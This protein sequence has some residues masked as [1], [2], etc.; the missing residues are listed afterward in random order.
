[1]NRNDRHNMRS[2]IEYR[3]VGVWERKLETET[4]NG[5]ALIALERGRR[6]ITWRVTS[7]SGMDSKIHA[8]IAWMKE[9]AFLERRLV[10]RNYN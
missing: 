10:T 9:R 7:A 1:M 3:L 4:G 2:T 6:G 5:N 8:T